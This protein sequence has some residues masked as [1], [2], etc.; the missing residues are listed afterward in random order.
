MEHGEL[1]VGYIAPDGFES[2]A[3]V[4]EPETVRQMEA[5]NGWPLTDWQR[6]TCGVNKHSD[7]PVALQWDDVAQVWR[8]LVLPEV[9][10]V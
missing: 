9:P 7:E 6:I 4:H 8:Q 1:K 5:E 2:T 10:G 3:Y